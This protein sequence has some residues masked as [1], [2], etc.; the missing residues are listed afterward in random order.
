MKIALT[1]SSGRVGRAIFAALCT[2]HDVIGIDR[3]PFS[4][5]HVLA[6]LDDRDTI[7][8]ALEGVDA[9]VH[10]AG[11]HAPHV[12][13]LPD[14][15]FERTNVETTHWLFEQAL[16]GGASRFVLT[17][18][19]ALY[20]HAIEPGRCTWV[21]EETVPLPRTIY[22]RTKLAAENALKQLACPQLPVRVLRMSR[23]F[24]EPAPI[25]ATYRLHRGVDVRDVASGHVLALGH[26]GAD[27]DCFILS[28]EPCFTPTD[29]AK[30]AENA[31][32]VLEARAPEWC[33]AFRARNWPLPR[34]ID[35]IYSPARA[36]EDLGW[37]PR[38]GWR[39]VLR[40]HDTGSLEVLPAEA[41]TAAKRE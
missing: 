10:T 32:P 5:T 36:V 30:L 4:T 12:G 13:A 17:S 11:P 23:C 18:T 35:R 24:P 34:A 27:Y 20:G 9:V 14:A 22:H 16:E 39:E 3:I 15:E 31:A 40:Q 29:C 41:K 33:E 1:G 28:G 19:T 26:E 37:I 38:Y 2:Q 6:D 7:A 25:M 8:R 21:D